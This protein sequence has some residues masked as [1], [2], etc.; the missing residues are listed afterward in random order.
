LFQQENRDLA[1]ILA[2]TAARGVPVLCLAPAGG[3]VTIPGIDQAKAAVPARLAFRRHEIITDLD[4]KLD[5]AAWPPDGPIAGRSIILK[6]EEG[7]VVG[8]V[9]RDA[10]GWPWV[11][12]DYPD[13]HSKLVYCC[14]GLFG[15][16]WETS[17]APRFLLA[18]M[19]EL[20]AKQTEDQTAKKKENEK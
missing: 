16:R 1:E 4:K 15:K 17:P 18:R 10:K 12:V 14:F 3:L 9:A 13:Q 20:L 7:S 2:K 11:Q 8:E 6:A 5:A 19:L